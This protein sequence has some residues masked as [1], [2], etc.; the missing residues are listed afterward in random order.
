M[1]LVADLPLPELDV[2][3]PEL[4]GERWHAAIDELRAGGHWLARAPLA[5]VVLDRAAG[6]HFLRTKAAIFPGVLIAEL[7][8][9]SDGPA[10]RAGHAQHHQRQRGR[11]SAAA[12][13]GQPGAGPA[14]GRPLPPGDARLPGASCG[15]RS[16]PTELELVDALSKPYPALTIATVMGAPLRT[17][18]GCTTGR[19]DPAP[20]RPH[21]AVRSPAAGGD[22]AQGGGVL[23]LGAAADRAPPRRS[24]RRPDPHADRGRGGGRPPRR[25][26]AGEPRPQHPRRWRRHDARASSPMRSGCWPPSPSS[27]RRCAPIRERL[28]PRAVE[29]VLRFEPITP[30]TARLLMEDVSSDGVTFPAGHRRS[31]VCAFTANRDA[32]AFADPDALRHHRRSRVGAGADLRRRHPLLRRRQPRPRRADRGRCAFLAERVRRSSSTASRELQNVS[33]IYGVDALP[34]AFT[35]A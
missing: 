4:R 19:V 11:P 7:F 2:S 35:P 18:R 16:R 31:M 6:E 22:P 28:A 30:L 17:R 5:T 9:I 27:G 10:A 26:R 12:Q 25:R 1:P 24:R 29:E 34:V 32:E 13:P 3:E 33:G 14:R 20:V 8:G 15:A 21:R 23:R